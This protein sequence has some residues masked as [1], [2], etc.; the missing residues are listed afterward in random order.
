MDRAKEVE[1][2]AV[3]A[4]RLIEENLAVDAVAHILDGVPVSLGEYPHMAAIGFSIIGNE[5][6]YDF[7]CG[8]TLIDPRFVL[9]AAH[10]VNSRESV[11]AVVRMG[12]VDFTDEEQMDDRVEIPVIKTHIHENYSSGSNYNDIALLQLERN[13]TYTLDVFPICLYTNIEDPPV[14]SILYVIGWGVVDVTTRRKSDVLLKAKLKITPL[15]ACNR[16]YAEQGLTR[17]ISQGII[18]SQMC[19]QD[20]S[21]MKDACQGDSGGPLNLVVNETTKNYRIIGIVS[22]GF[23]CGTETPGF[24]TRVAAFLD[25]IESIVWP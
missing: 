22:A 7:R 2:P 13:V 6:E 19:A 3:R 24:Y 15:S 9:T 25:Y 12:V 11:P 21:E 17:H 14:D 5:D 10:C 20:D 23:S 1:R 4:C 16:S 18:S 8:G